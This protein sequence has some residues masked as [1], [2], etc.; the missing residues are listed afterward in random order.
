MAD[1]SAASQ[2]SQV[3][4]E[5]RGP[6]ATGSSTTNVRSTPEWK[7]WLAGFAAHS[8]KGLADTIDEALLRFSR[9]E[10]YAPPPRR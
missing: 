1:T 4:P 3:E 10:S 2:A 7:A 5:P 9:A 8:R 6:A